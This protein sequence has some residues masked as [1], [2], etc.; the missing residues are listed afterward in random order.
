[1]KT[2]LYFGDL[3]E[4]KINW[5]EELKDEQDPDDEL[6]PETP[7]D[8]VDLLGFDPLEFEEE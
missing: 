1:M 5:R 3:E 7:K 4:H 6:L 8:V 2:D